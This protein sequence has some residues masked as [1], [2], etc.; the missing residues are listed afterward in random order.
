MNGYDFEQDLTVGKQFE[1]FV[2]WLYDRKRQIKLQIHSTAAEQLGIGECPQGVEIKFDSNCSYTR[3]LSIEYEAANKARTCWQPSGIWKDDNAIDYIQGDFCN[4]FIFNKRCLQ[5]I[6]TLR[7][8]IGK[9][10]THQER[11]TVRAWYFFL[12]RRNGGA[13]DGKLMPTLV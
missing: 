10:Q 1:R 12:L 3:R 2:C 9:L 13:T 5:T 7:R 8:K 4:V 11:G 6:F